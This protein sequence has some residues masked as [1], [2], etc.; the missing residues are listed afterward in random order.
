MN[1]K[2][3][4]PNCKSNYPSNQSTMPREALDLAIESLKDKQEKD[5]KPI[6]VY[7]MNNTFEP[8]KYCIKDKA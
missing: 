5:S 1:C 3:N 2:S 7:D 4:Y 8:I 6:W